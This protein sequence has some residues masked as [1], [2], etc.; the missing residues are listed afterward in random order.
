MIRGDAD[1]PHRPVVGCT[2][3]ATRAGQSIDR[4]FEGER[5]ESVASF[6]ISSSTI[7]QTTRILRSTRRRARCKPQVAQRPDQGRLL[8]D[9]SEEAWRFAGASGRISMSHQ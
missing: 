1:Q 7:D 2:G 9:L 6:A 8:M 5:T 4:P 3:G